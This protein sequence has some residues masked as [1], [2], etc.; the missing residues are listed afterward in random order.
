MNSWSFVK[1]LGL[2]ILMFSAISAQQDPPAGAGD[3]NL[4]D[5][6]V[7]SRSIELERVKRDAEKQNP[8]NPTQGVPAVKFQEIKEDFEGLQLR[9]D[10]IR[11]IYTE[12]KQIDTAKIAVVAGVMNANATR[13]LGNLFP[14]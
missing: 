13:L 9:Q 12:G 11:K 3:K 14:P 6:N 7:K 5:R 2:S 1:D 4:E 8:K 10:E